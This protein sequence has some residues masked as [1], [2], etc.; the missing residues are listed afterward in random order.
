MFAII[1][2]AI[3]GHFIEASHASRHDKSG[4]KVM[5]GRSALPSTDRSTVWLADLIEA[6]E[7]VAASAEPCNPAAMQAFSHRLAM[8]ADVQT[9]FE[10]VRVG[11][12]QLARA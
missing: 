3:Y 11:Q 9:W 6:A 1:V 7:A 10:P 12:H 4:R 8:G 5:M 2:E